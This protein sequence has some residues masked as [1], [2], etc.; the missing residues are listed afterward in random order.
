MDGFPTYTHTHTH[1][2][3]QLLLLKSSIFFS[4]IQ[5]YVPYIF[6]SYL[7]FSEF[8]VSCQPT[9]SN[10]LFSTLDFFLS[11]KDFIEYKYI[12]KILRVQLDE[13]PHREHSH[14]NSNKVKKQNIDWNPEAS[15]SHLLLLTTSCLKGNHYSDFC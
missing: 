10:Q 12:K 14:I 8:I 7:H 5:L 6:I 15:V 2:H 3:T 11:F 1:T 13:F 9:G 4:L